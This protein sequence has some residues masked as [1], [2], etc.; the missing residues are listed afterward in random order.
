VTAKEI[1]E[2]MAVVAIRDPGVSWMSYRRTAEACMAAVAAAIAPKIPD[3]PKPDWHWDLVGVYAEMRHVGRE[4]ACVELGLVPKP[5][6]TSRPLLKS[7][8]SCFLRLVT[9]HGNG[10]RRRLK[11]KLDPAD[12]RRAVRLV[13]ELYPCTDFLNNP[14]MAGCMCRGVVTM[15]LNRHRPPWKTHPS[16]SRWDFVEEYMDLKGIKDRKAACLE[17]GL[18]DALPGPPFGLLADEEE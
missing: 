18:H 12:V 6:S 7:E 16:E 15:T 10:T 11:R 5:K 3:A 8:W 4:S 1:A 13:Q 2:A 17:L 14:W 9:N